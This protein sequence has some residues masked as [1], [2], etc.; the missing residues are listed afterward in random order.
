MMKIGRNAPCPCGSGKKHKKCC[1]GKHEGE[2]YQNSPAPFEEIPKEVP[3]PPQYL[4]DAFKRMRAVEK[5]TGLPFHWS[6]EEA[7]EYET[8]EIIE[9]LRSFGIE[10]DHATFR[11]DTERF[12]S[13]TQLAKNW[14]DSFDLNATGR[15]EDFPWFAAMVLWDRLA[16]ETP[17]SEQLDDRAADGYSLLEERRVT[18]A[19]DV[20]LSVWGTV[21]EH[22]AR[23][24]RSAEQLDEVLNLY[25]SIFNWCQD[26][27]MEL[28]NAA[29]RD[30]AYHQKRQ[31]YCAEFIETFPETSISITRNMK[32]AIAA[33]WF[34]LGDTLRGDAEFQRLIDDSPDDCWHYVY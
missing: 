21:K 24:F 25:Q 16:P 31:T 14:R 11:E 7:E 32:S 28:R 19:C 22:F 30:A 10:F 13:G 26:L 4:L 33:S 12:N 2:T 27:E 8:D 20:W 1:L 9:K 5:A 17:Y 29:L 34:G 23:G 3:A 15:D 18:E 6:K